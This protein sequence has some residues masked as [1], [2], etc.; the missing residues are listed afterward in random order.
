MVQLL[1]MRHGQAEPLQRDD[2]QRQLTQQGIHEV[3]QMG[4]WLS[5][6]VEHI[7]MLLHSPYVRAVQTATQVMLP[8]LSPNFQQESEDLIPSGNPET[9]CDYVDALIEIKQPKTILIVSHMPLV[10]YL[11]ERFTR[12][13]STDI[14]D[15]AG[16]A[17]IDY[18]AEEM[19]GTLKE[20]SSPHSLF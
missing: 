15:T 1:I 13:T 12:N 4:Q 11:L 3:T 7:D 5:K 8:F 16:I 6:R 14:F 10:S 2:A 20:M 18:D 9:V 19:C 17:Q